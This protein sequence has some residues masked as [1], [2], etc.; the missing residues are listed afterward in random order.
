MSDRVWRILPFAVVIVIAGCGGHGR[1]SAIIPAPTATS[2]P[3]LTGWSLEALPGTVAEQP[4][5]PAAVRARLKQYDAALPADV[6]ETSGVIKHLPDDT[7]TVH[8]TYPSP[9]FYDFRVSSPFDAQSPSPLNI[10]GRLAFSGSLAGHYV[11]VGLVNNATY[12]YAMDPDGDPLTKD[13]NPALLF[14]QNVVMVCAADA[15]GT[16]FAAPLDYDN[17]AGIGQAQAISGNG[18]SFSLQLVPSGATGGTL[19]LAVNGGELGQNMVYG[20]NNWGWWPAESFTQAR[21]IVQV[22]SYNTD[23]APFSVSFTNVLADDPHYTPPPPGSDWVHTWGT[24]NGEA[25]VSTAVAYGGDVDAVGY[26]NDYNVALVEQY[27]PDG[28]L[29]WIH[30]LS[31]PVNSAFR[32]VATDTSGNIYCLGEASNQILLVKLDNNGTLIWSKAWFELEFNYSTALATDNSGNVYLAGVT[33]IIAEDYGISERSVLFKLGPSGNVLKQ[34]EFMF[35][36][37]GLIYSLAICNGQ[38]FA[39]DGLEGAVD[40]HSWLVRYNL[41]LQLQDAHELSGRYGLPWQLS[42]GNGN[43]LLISGLPQDGLDF[44][45]LAAYDTSTAKLVWQQE[46]TVPQDM[47]SPV[48]LQVQAA[49]VDPSG[50]AFVC[51]T[52]YSNTDDARPFAAA[53]DPSGKFLSA[54]QVEFAAPNTGGGMFGLV[55]GREGEIYVGGYAKN[56]SGIRWADSRLMVQASTRLSIAPATVPSML[57]P[58][59]ALKDFPCPLSTPVGVIDIGGGLS[60]ALVMRHLLPNVPHSSGGYGPIQIDCTALS[61]ARF[62]LWDPVG[63]T[64]YTGSL[65]TNS[66]FDASDTLF[67]GD[68]F[69]VSFG[70]DSALGPDDLTV[71]PPAPDGTAG[72]YVTVTPYGLVL[73]GSLATWFAIPNGTNTLQLKTLAYSRVTNSMAAGLPNAFYTLRDTSTNGTIGGPWATNASSYQHAIL[74]NSTNFRPVFSPQAYPVAGSATAHGGAVETIYPAEWTNNW[75]RLQDGAISEQGSGTYPSMRDYFTQSGLTNT[76]DSD[77][78]V[79]IESNAVGVNFAPYAFQ[80]SPGFMTISPALNQV[81]LPP[82]VLTLAK[83]DSFRCLDSAGHTSQPLLAIQAG[84]KLNGSNATTLN[85]NGGGGAVRLNYLPV[86]VW[87]D[88]DAQDP[89]LTVNGHG[90]WTVTLAFLLQYGSGPWTVQVD[91]DY[92]AGWNDGVPGMVYSLNES[93]FGTAGLKSVTLQVPRSHPAG[94][95]RFALQVTDSKSQQ[96]IYIWPDSVALE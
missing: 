46:L 59:G 17:S 28:R 33:R 53:F 93:P 88:P 42:T 83:F 64:P 11:E 62:T 22:Y 15:A 87:D 45:I 3:Q 76:L 72:G 52:L 47:P 32:R 27:S 43:R 8:G 60:D 10:T 81:A 13:A 25:I 36:P 26:V 7:V 65:S 4:A 55:A 24:A 84:H 94:V 57:P 41:D 86:R 67:V 54:Q 29:K 40:G 20:K 89:G 66:V 91:T 12:N 78:F 68:R 85:F 5:D 96:Y 30:E 69:Y 74:A 39:L 6:R 79:R 77:A 38:L 75:F 9:G 14:N 2:K 18:L 16:L 23:P 82:D 71:Y 48:L 49:R 70:V 34:V 58:A 50:N 73:G 61:N 51:G 90:P 1:A 56:A 21:L 35:H 37:G 31:T 19:S 63:P 44:G 95:F 92:G 80:L